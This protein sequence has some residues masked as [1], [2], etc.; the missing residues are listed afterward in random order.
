MAESYRAGMT[1]EERNR[2][3]LAHNSSLACYCEGCR[4]QEKG[5]TLTADAIVKVFAV[6]TEEDLWQ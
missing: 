6:E 1:A 2:V 5:R 4:E 3:Y